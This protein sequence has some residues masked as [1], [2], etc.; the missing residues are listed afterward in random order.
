MRHVT[1]YQKTHCGTPPILFLYV[2]NK[3]KSS[4]NY[5]FSEEKCLSEIPGIIFDY[6]LD[7]GGVSMVLGAK[8]LI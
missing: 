7:W 6:C 1:E 5:C 4:I 8:V 2:M 3:K